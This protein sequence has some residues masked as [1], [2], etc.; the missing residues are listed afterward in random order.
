MSWLLLLLFV[1]L[2]VMGVLEVPVVPLLV[3]LPAP[4]LVLLL[5]M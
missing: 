4:L 3:L 1:C 2:F 5:M